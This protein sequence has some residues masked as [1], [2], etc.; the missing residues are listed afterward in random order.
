MPAELRG[1]DLH[2]GGF[3][4]AVGAPP[5]GPAADG[6]AS[7]LSLAAGAMPSRPTETDHLAG[8]HAAL[9]DSGLGGPMQCPVQSSEFG[10]RELV[11]WPGGRDLGLPQRFVG[12]EVANS[13]DDRLV[14]QSRLD[15]GPSPSHPFDELIRT[16]QLGIRSQRIKI[17]VQPYATEPAWIEQPHRAAITEGDDEPIPDAHIPMGAGETT[18]APVHPVPALGHVAVSVGD[19]HMPAHAEVESEDRSGLAGAAKPR[20]LAPHR[21][22]PPE[23]A[24]ER[25]ADQRGVNLTGRVR[26]TLPGIG[27]VDR[28]DPAAESRAFDRRTGTFDLR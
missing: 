16:D 22:A 8:V 2:G 13:S 23:R 17:G 24:R 26:S 19:Q 12:E 15:R 6:S 21:L 9:G 1:E 14:Q 11:T 3:R 20:R 18:V 4:R 7:H 10:H 28:S 27:V 5:R 25:T